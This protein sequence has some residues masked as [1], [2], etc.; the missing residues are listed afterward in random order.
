M[1]NNSLLMLALAL[2]LM[3]LGQ[4]NGFGQSVSGTSSSNPTVNEK[5]RESFEKEASTELKDWE[6]K[7]TQLRADLKKNHRNRE[8]NR[9]LKRAIRHLESDLKDVKHQLSKLKVSSQK[10]FKHYEDHIRAEFDDMKMS[11]NKAISE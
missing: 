2:S 10:D 9:Q 11:Y 7:V 5:E 8:Q 4:R 6:E 3:L 1:R